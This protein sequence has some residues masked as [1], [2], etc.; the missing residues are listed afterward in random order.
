MTEIKRYMT[1]VFRASFPN[2]R[3]AREGMTGDDGKKGKPKYGISAIWT[4]SKFS[5]SEKKQWR[6]LRQAINAICLER[7]KKGEKDLP[8]NYK[9]GL[10]DGAEKEELEGYGAGT[11]FAN[12]TTMQR[13]GVVRADRTPISIEEM[14]DEVYPGCYMRAT[15]TIYTY[16]NKGKGYAIGLMNLQK[17]KD[18]PRL[19]SRVN[20]EQDFVEDVDSSWLDEDEDA[21]GSVDEEFLD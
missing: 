9:H 19:D 11:K 4:P 15:V 10:R 3:E 6:T 13:P 2:V 5:E 8:A 17:V 20:A 18:G 14:D 16:N 1:P 7:F 12:L 21:V